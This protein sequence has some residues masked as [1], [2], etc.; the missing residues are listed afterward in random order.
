[1]SLIKFVS[2]TI[3]GGKKG[4]ELPDVKTV[5]VKGKLKEHFLYVVESLL[6]MDTSG[7]YGQVDKQT[8][9]NYK[10][11]D[12]EVYMLFQDGGIRSE[13]QLVQVTGVVPN[14]HVIRYT[15]AGETFRS[16]YM[17]PGLSTYSSVYTDMRKYSHV[18]PDAKWFRLI[19][20]VNDL[21]GF[22]FVSLDTEGLH[23]APR[24]D[25]WIS[26]EGQKFVYL[27]MAESY[28]TPDGYKRVLLLSDIPYL[29]KEAQIKLLRR[30]SDI[31]GFGVT[32]STAVVE[33]TDITAGSS[34]SFLSV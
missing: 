21:L 17:E 19:A 20:M 27:L 10:E 31:P 29:E 26:V 30:L 1:M 15:G 11:L 28:L 8:G 16:F 24:A 3:D 22:E 2:M 32:L 7:Y 12:E 13:N 14:T 25:C 4:V 33:F 5:I 34:I 6:A 18:I 23:F 9:S